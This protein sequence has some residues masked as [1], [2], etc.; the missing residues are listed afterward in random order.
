MIISNPL[1]E[2]VG[3]YELGNEFGQGTQLNLFWKLGVESAK[4]VSLLTGNMHKIIV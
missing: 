1:C 3:N 2:N 4:L